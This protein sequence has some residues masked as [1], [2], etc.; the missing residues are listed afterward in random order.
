MDPKSLLGE[1]SQAHGEGSFTV[2]FSLSFQQRSEQRF[3]AVLRHNASGH[4][5]YGDES[6][7]KRETERQACDEMYRH[8]KHNPD[9]LR[10][11]LVGDVQ[12]ESAV[13][14]RTRRNY[15]DPKSLLGEWSQ[16]RGLGPFASSFVMS[17][18]QLDEQLFRAT[19][20][21]TASG[22]SVIGARST[23]K[24]G[25]ELDACQK[26]YDHLTAKPPV[27][28]D[29]L[30]DLQSPPGE[31]LRVSRDSVLARSVAAS[32]ELDYTYMDTPLDYKACLGEWSEDRGLG[33][34]Q[35]N[36]SL[37][38]ELL[39]E[40][41][42]RACVIHLD[43]DHEILAEPSIGKRVT[44]RDACKL[45]LEYVQALPPAA[46][47]DGRQA[48]GT[49][50]Q[51]DAWLG[52]KVLAL[53]LAVALADSPLPPPELEQRV[54]ERMRDEVLAS[55]MKYCSGLVLPGKGGTTRQDADEVRRYIWE[56][57]LVN[58]Q[59]IM[60][61]RIRLRALLD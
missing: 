49:G 24:K 15:T 1:W 37:T 13:G 21:H 11:G 31:R 39:G 36:F 6:V 35:D 28:P 25:S 43:T 12:E 60:K 61:T 22:Y 52:E 29:R 51:R 9:V 34:F 54:S 56:S 48:K 41:R 45:M 46:A 16:S 20:T 58:G 33:T 3:Q 27:M 30:A 47:A 8:L 23:G 53:C 44:E 14:G 5:T 57:Y 42:Y 38:F 18:E 59:D 19:L 7:G 40:Q 10:A 50:Q 17:V 55:R 2:A 26:M 32:D 4:V